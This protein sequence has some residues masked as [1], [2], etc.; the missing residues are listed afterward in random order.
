M[1]FLRQELLDNQLTK[2]HDD[3]KQQVNGLRKLVQ[4]TKASHE[5]RSN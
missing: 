3:L 1:H 2:D 5:S 4:I